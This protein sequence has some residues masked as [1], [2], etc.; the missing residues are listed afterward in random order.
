MLSNKNFTFM[1]ILK[2]FIPYLCSLLLQ[3]FIY[4]ADVAIIFV[5]NVVADKALSKSES[6]LSIINEHYRQPMN[7]AI[8]SVMIYISYIIGFGIWQQ[9]INHTKNITDSYRL[10][11]KHFSIF[12]FCITLG[13]SGQFF[14]DSIL[15]LARHISPKAL[16]NYDSMIDNVFGAS[17]SAFTL[18]YVFLLAPIAEELLFRG[19]TLHYCQRLFKPVWAAVINSL[20]FSV[21]HG[22]PIQMIYAFF[23]GLILALLAQRTGRLI[24]GMVAHI[25]VNTSILLIG[26][27]TFDTV[28]ST[29]IT[30]TISLFGLAISC[31]I[32]YKKTKKTDTN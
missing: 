21:Y 19:V 15:S 20:L 9:R 27:F 11:K 17:T 30:G 5:Y 32:L 22:Q 7:L 4:I 28:A 8:V 3:Y 6:A 12:I 16:A 23:F 10:S 24:F 2:I 13:I 31:Y 18:L 29:I 14:T 26:E 25:A 1:D